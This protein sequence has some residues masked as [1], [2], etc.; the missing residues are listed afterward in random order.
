MTFGALFPHLDE[1]QRRLLLGAEARVLGH[2]LPCGTAVVSPGLPGRPG[3]LMP[4]SGPWSGGRSL[5]EAR[6]LRQK[7]SSPSG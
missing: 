5:H 3:P 2:W 1:R 6:G 4:K 7:T